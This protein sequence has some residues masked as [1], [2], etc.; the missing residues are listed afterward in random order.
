LETIYN[1]VEFEAYN[2]AKRQIIRIECKQG[3]RVRYALK[4]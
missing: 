3:L 1:Q 2:E 4:I